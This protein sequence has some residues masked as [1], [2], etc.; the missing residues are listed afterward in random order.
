MNCHEFNNIMV[1][2]SKTLKFSPKNA[3]YFIKFFNDY[4]KILGKKI[5]HS[6]TNH[7]TCQAT[8]VFRVLQQQKILNTKKKI[9]SLCKN[10]KNIVTWPKP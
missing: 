10:F 6:T 2:L 3:D 8:M 5:K 4:V 1:G 7:W 9:A